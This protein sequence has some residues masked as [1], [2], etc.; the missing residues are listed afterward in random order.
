MNIYSAHVEVSSFLTIFETVV[1]TLVIENKVLVFHRLF[2]D[3][4]QHS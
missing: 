1:T 2:Y 3:T 4:K